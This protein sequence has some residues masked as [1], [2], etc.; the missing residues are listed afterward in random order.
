M[1]TTFV[2]I[3]GEHGF[4]MQDANLELWLRLLALHLPEPS[5]NDS[6]ERHC[7]VRRIRDQWLLASKGYFVGCVPDGMDDAAKLTDGLLVVRQAVDSIMQSLEKAP[8]TLSKDVLNLLGFWER[9]VL[10]IEDFETWRL[11]EV[12]H[13]F[14]GLI[15]GK[16][17]GTGSTEFMP[18]SRSEAD[19]NQ[20]LRGW[21]RRE[22]DSR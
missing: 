11:L 16:I 17:T 5:D 1:G 7:T 8:K 9:G 19:L 12:G 3:D 6:A 21:P 2:T 22:L 20:R 10:W 13:A 14:V 15:E 18:G 4:W